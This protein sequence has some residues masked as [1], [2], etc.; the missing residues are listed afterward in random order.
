[1]ALPALAQWHFQQFQEAGSEVEASEGKSGWATR[2]PV[3]P[4]ARA[5][6]G[7]PHD[8]LLD[9]VSDFLEELKRHVKWQGGAVSS[10][11]RVLQFT[12]R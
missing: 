3:W 8:T 6:A 5:T 2:G 9:G 11:A 1:M 10:E 12:A 4:R 7:S